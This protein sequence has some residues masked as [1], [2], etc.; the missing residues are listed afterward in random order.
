MIDFA[1]DIKKAIATLNKGGIII[2]PTD[3]IW[4]IGCDATNEKA[5]NKIYKTKLRSHNKSMIV[6]LDDV[7]KLKLYLNEVPEIAISLM[8]QINTPLTIIYPSARN[9][10]KNVFAEDGTVAI[11]IVKDS[12]CLELCKTFD[13]PLV[14]TSA[15]ISGYTYPLVFRDI[16]ERLLKSAD[17]IMESGRTLIRQIKPSTIVKLKS[18]WDYEIIRS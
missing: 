17:Y 8:E 5:V 3:T 4:G 10:A 13:K 1:D 14:S 18:N 12:F 15:N 16:D 6:L 7:E 2:Y 11:R 9:L